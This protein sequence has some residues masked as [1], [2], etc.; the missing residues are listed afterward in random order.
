MDLHQN[1]FIRER[2]KEEMREG[3]RGNSDRLDSESLGKSRN[4]ELWKNKMIGCTYS[5][6]ISFLTAILLTVWS[7]YIFIA[8][9]WD[10]HWC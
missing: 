10:M 5:V 1:R 3:E 9:G 4:K 6:S 2:E 7:R 8:E